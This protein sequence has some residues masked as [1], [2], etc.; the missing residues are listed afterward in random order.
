MVNITPVAIV[1]IFV[2][3]LAIWPFVAQLSSAQFRQL[4]FCKTVS[5][6][7]ILCAYVMSL[8]IEAFYLPVALHAVAV[9]ATAFLLLERWRARSAYGV[10]TGL[11]P[12]SLALMPRQPFKDPRF[13]EQQI[14]RHG[15]IFK[16]SRGFQPFIC[17]YG[18]KRGLNFLRQNDDTLQ[19]VALPFS[20]HIPGGFLRYMIPD[21]HNHYRGV[22][23]KHFSVDTIEGNSASLNT[24]ISTTLNRMTNECRD[25]STGR[26]NPDPQLREMVFDYLVKLILGVN[27][28]DPE[29]AQLRSHYAVID[30]R[31]NPCGSGRKKERATA[32]L[33]SLVRQ[34]ASFL[35]EYKRQGADD[36]NS[37]LQNS[38]DS[39][40]DAS[41]DDT[42][43]GNLIFMVELGT[44]DVTGLLR[45]TLKLLSDNPDWIEHLRKECAGSLYDR[46]NASHRLA[47][48]IFKET[49]RLE[50]IE[51]LL[52]KSTDE[53]W[54][55]GFRIPK[56]WRIRICIREGNR[57]SGTF[58]KPDE[59]D[60]NRFRD[61]QYSSIEYSPFGL[62]RHNC[63]GAYLTQNICCSFILNLVQN[64]D[65][66]AGPKWPSEH[67]L[68]HWEPC[69]GHSLSLR[70][71]RA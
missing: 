46:E 61:N 10:S 30:I 22:I 27:R 58:P 38:I 17:I 39:I 62:Y 35:R 13:I 47:E 50:Q 70:H 67:G 14:E 59:F 7:G 40:R 24:M 36:K 48:H 26:V 21:A 4:S 5:R 52:R 37:I 29:Y 51:F 68:F 9:F 16:T 34:R 25:G 60:P 2:C 55:E 15:P 54:F 3:L 1:E 56:N 18:H 12:G 6:F 66:D 41:S 8:A 71:R 28:T 42:I 64:F 19:G 11:P 20:R 33:T 32:E 45:W 44:N 53:I 65:F 69:R 23:Q 43:I 31:T 49:L 63:L 57:N